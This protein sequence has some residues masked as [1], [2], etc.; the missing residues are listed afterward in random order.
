MS[1]SASST[2]SPPIPSHRDIPRTLWFE[3]GSVWNGKKCFSTKTPPHK[4]QNNTFNTDATD[5]SNGTNVCPLILSHRCAGEP[6]DR[7]LKTDSYLL[8][9][10]QYRIL[11]AYKTARP[12]QSWNWAR[13]TSVAVFTTGSRAADLVM[14]VESHGHADKMVTF[15]WYFLQ[16]VP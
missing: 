13:F 1:G 12:A 8:V 2:T 15:H 10:W 14:R 4:T 11:S 3:S 9:D 6:A 7:W 16:K 5:P